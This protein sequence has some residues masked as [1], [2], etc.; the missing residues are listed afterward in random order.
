[1]HFTEMFTA[2]EISPFLLWP[3]TEPPSQPQQLPHPFFRDASHNTSRL[4]PRFERDESGNAAHSMLAG[5]R[6]VFIDID[7]NHQRLALQFLRE[8]FYHRADDLARA[9]PVGVKFHQH[10]HLGR[11]HGADGCRA[12]H[13]TA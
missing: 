7:A 6:R 11:A 2:T 3:L 13:T 12:A 10:G 8:L 5:K 1:M 9:A 4:A